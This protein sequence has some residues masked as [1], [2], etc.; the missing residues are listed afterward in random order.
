MEKEQVQRGHAEITLCEHLVGGQP[1]KNGLKDVSYSPYL[2][3]LAQG[4]TPIMH[5][6]HT[7]QLNK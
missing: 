7:S 2:H 4:L 5:A 6:E 3:C 1:R